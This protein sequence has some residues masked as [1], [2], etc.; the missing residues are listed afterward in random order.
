MYS[1]VHISVCLHSAE[2]YHNVQYSTYIG[3]LA[4]Q[5]LLE[6]E[7]AWHNFEK[8]SR[9][10][11]HENPSSGG[12]SCS[13]CTDGQADMTKLTVAFSFSIMR[14][15]LKWDASGLQ[16]MAM[17]ELFRTQIYNKRT[18]VLLCTYISLLSLRCTFQAPHMVLLSSTF[19]AY[20]CMQC[21]W[22]NN[23]T[24]FWTKA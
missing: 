8:S 17:W 22:P 3:L 15:H 24:I 6:L 11:F 2:C 1:T 10:T 16:G 20:Q 12:P 14:K 19:L 9:I 18:S 7:F 23:N 13:M 21:H 5:A 4:C